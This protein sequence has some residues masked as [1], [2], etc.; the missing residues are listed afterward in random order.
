M[1]SCYCKL[2]LVQPAW[3]VNQRMCAASTTSPR[4]AHPNAF[5]ET[6][7]LTWYVNS[8]MCRSQARIE[9]A[10][11]PPTLAYPSSPVSPLP[12]SGGCGWEGA[13]GK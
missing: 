6:E 10:V 9:A 12:S 8:R 7:S 2:V 4:L 11:V 13:M 5:C 3:Y 1:P